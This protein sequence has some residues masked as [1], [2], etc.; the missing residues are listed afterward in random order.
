MS[1]YA[2]ADISAFWRDLA[3]IGALI[4]VSYERKLEE[5]D[6]DEDYGAEDHSLDLAAAE[7]EPSDAPYADDVYRE[8]LNLARSS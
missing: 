8:D 4:M 3:L 7:P 6:A 2:G 1:M 5:S